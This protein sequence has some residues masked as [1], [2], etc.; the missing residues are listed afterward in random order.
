MNRP[1]SRTYNGFSGVD[2]V[3]GETEL[4]AIE[5][6]RDKAAVVGQILLSRKK[7]LKQLPRVFTVKIHGYNAAIQQKYRMEI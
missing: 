3:V 4:Q 5:F 2:I 7:D 6:T 1:Y